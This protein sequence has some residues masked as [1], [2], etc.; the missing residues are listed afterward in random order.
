MTSEPKTSTEEPTSAKREEIATLYPLLTYH[1]GLSFQEIADMPRWAR[2]DY[3]KALPKL[4]AQNQLR[5]IEV[6]AFPN[7]K[8]GARKSLV[9]RLERAAR[10]ARPQA[11]RPRKIEDVAMLGIGVKK[12][13]AE[14]N[15]LPE[16]ADA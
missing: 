3:L 6:S 11:I 7:M 5:A 4:I 8:D 14:G 2:R 13:D 1:Y 12:V 9:R 15:P 16:D 10:H